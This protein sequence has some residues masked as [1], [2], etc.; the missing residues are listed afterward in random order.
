[1]QDTYDL[2]I[3][4]KALN[5][6]DIDPDKVN[7]DQYYSEASSSDPFERDREPQWCP[8]HLMKTQQSPNVT[9]SVSSG[10]SAAT[11][12]AAPE[13][14]PQGCVPSKVYESI[15]DEVALRIVKRITSGNSH[16]VCGKTT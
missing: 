9:N 12:D 7:C 14:R 1:M 2:A 3:T 10:S 5:M 6:V 11:N 8:L 15:I 4:P 13:K 16:H